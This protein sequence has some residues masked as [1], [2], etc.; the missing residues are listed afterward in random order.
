MTDLLAE[1]IK[2]RGTNTLFNVAQRTPIKSY[3]IDFS[4]QLT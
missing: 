4:P 2:G 3:R 1:V